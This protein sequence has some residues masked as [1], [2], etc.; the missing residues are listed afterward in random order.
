MPTRC[1]SRVAKYR[2]I[3]TCYAK[4]HCASVKMSE[5]ASSTPGETYNRSVILFSAKEAAHQCQICRQQLDGTQFA[6]PTTDP[7]PPALSPQYGSTSILSENDTCLTILTRDPRDVYSKRFSC[8]TITLGRWHKTNLFVAWTCP[9]H[10]SHK[11]SFPLPNFSILRRK[12]RDASQLPI[13]GPTH[14]LE[15]LSLV[16]PLFL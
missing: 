14:F 15:T 16:S 12:K 13:D 3:A 11:Y 5:Q 8:I 9:L 6:R 7:Q 4:G 2:P 1:A 10:F